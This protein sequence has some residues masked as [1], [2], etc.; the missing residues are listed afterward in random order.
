[1]VIQNLSSSTATVDLYFYDQSGTQQ[2]LIN[3]HTI[4]GDAAVPFNTRAGGD[5]PASTFNALGDN[6]T[7]SAYITS[8]QPILGIANTR[9]NRASDNKATQWNLVGQ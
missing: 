9:W 2:L 8:N 4:A 7:G 1:L 3:N 5:V 6:F